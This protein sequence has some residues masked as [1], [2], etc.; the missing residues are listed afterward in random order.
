MKTNQRTD[1]EKTAQGL[2]QV[3][4]Y[5]LTVRNAPGEFLMVPKTELEVDSAYQRN[6]STSGAWMP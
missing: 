2:D 3:T 6:K 1:E 5:N 4:R